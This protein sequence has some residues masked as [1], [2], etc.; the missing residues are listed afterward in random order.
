VPS[1][2]IRGNGHKLK[3]KRLPL[4]IRKHVFT[5]RVTEPWNRLPRRILQ[6]HTFEIFE[7]CLDIDVGN[8]L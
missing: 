3:H 6:S 2:K 8:L 7:S 1:D 4:I 5:V